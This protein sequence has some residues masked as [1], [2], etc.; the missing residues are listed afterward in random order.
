MSMLLESSGL[1]DPLAERLAD[2]MPVFGTCAGMILLAARGARRPARPAQLRRHRHRRAPQRLRP[3]GRHRSRPTSTSPASTAA[4]STP[5]SSARRSSSASGDDVEVLRRS[6]RASR[7]SCRQGPV[8]VAAFHPE[9]SGDRRLHELL[10][11]GGLTACPAIPSGQRSSTRRAPTDKARGQA[12]RQAD[13]PG[14]GRG[15]RGRRRPRGQPDAA[16]DVPE[17]PRPRRCR[18]TPSSGRSSGAPASSRA[19]P[20]SDHL[21]GLRARRRRGARRGAHRQPQPH[22]RRGPQHLHARTAARWPSPAR[23]RGS[24]S[25]RAWSSS[26][27]AVDEDDAD[28]GR[29][30]RRRRGHRRRGRHVAGDVRRRPTS[31]DGARPRSRRPASPSSRPTLTM[32]ADHRRSPLDDAEDGA[33]RCCG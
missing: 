20:T 8:I 24:S 11:A 19:S 22:R 1:F 6:R 18:S 17:G 32:V 5:C 4:R 33:R 23:W 25:A 2:G 28:A 7:C 3:P 9:L 30:R 27:G 13:P 10:P 12:L 16:H 15:P 21:R 14:R 29:A 31:H 26:P